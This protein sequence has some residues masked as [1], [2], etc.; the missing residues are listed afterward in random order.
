MHYLPPKLWS[1]NAEIVVATIG[2]QNNPE[3]AYARSDELIATLGSNRC[4]GLDSRR[5]EMKTS[6]INE[7]HNCRSH[8]PNIYNISTTV[9]RSLC[10]V[11]GHTNKET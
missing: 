11:Q 1:R 10:S 8:V 6:R 9:H 4:D 3:P 2:K 5:Q 7:A